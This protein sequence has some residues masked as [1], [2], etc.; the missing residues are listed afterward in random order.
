MAKTLSLAA[1]LLGCALA[2]AVDEAPKTVWGA[3]EDP[4]K[5]CA[6][7]E[8]KGSLSISVPGKDHDLG[9][10]RAK[11]NAPRAMQPV[12]GDFTVQVKVTGKFDP[13]QMIN[14]ERLAY[15]GAGFG[16]IPKKRPLETPGNRLTHA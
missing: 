1:V 8:E 16:P 15:H 12:E 9:I 14:L 11:M 6:F 2:G 13:R 5:D 3:F 4:D 10:E 7:K